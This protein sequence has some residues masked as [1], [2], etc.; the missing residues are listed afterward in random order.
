[1]LQL[2]APSTSSVKTDKWAR[3]CNLIKFRDHFPQMRFFCPAEWANLTLESLD[4]GN[5]KLSGTLPAQWGDLSIGSQ[6]HQSLQKLYLSN[7]QFWGAFPSRWSNFSS[8]TSFTI[9]GNVQLCDI[10]P[11]PFVCIDTSE[12]RLGRS[13]WFYILC[14][15]Y[16][17]MKHTL[18][19]SNTFAFCLAYSLIFP[20]GETKALHH[21]NVPFCVAILWIHAVLWQYPIMYYIIICITQLPISRRAWILINFGSSIQPH[22]K[23][24]VDKTFI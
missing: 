6:L 20:M 24:L 16:M 7:N 9:F 15:L 13:S 4:L 2:S 10:L 8:L 18:Y 22:K 5:N 17:W 12:T 23:L 11:S 14:L 1:M 3:T 21:F 19:S